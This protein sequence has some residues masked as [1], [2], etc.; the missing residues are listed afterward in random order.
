MFETLSLPEKK[1]QVAVWMPCFNAERWVVQAVSSVLKQEGVDPVLIVFDDC[2]TDSTSEILRGLSEQHPKQVYV[3]RPLVNSFVAGN[4]SVRMALLEMVQCDFIAILDADDFW[5]SS[6]KLRTSMEAIQRSG[7]PAAGHAVNILGENSQAAKHRALN[8]AISRQNLK[9]KLFRAQGFLPWRVATCTLV[10]RRQAFPF[11]LQDQIARAPAMDLVIKLG[12]LRSGPIEFIEAPLAT[13]RVHAE[14]AWSS[15]SVVGKSVSTFGILLALRKCLG[16][17]KS[18]LTMCY[19]AAWAMLNARM[20]VS[21]RLR[22][23]SKQHDK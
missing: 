1:H 2:S 3:S 6:A 22:R 20:S 18:A 19:G 5:N 12:V 23:W 10:V 7:A 8:E 14:S 13:Y 17:K 16:V 9:S 15:R 21:V 11:D 4:K